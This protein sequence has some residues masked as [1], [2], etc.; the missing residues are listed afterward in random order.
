MKRTAVVGV[1]AVTMALAGMTL[2]AHDEQQGQ[3][4]GQG[5]QAGRAGGG[6]R[7]GRGNNVPP[8]AKGECPQGMTLVRV[9]SCGTPEFPPP[10]IVDYRPRTTLVSTEHLVPK[11]KFPVIDSHNHTTITAANIDQM[12]KEMDENNIRT[13][14]NLSGGA[15]PAGVK[16]KV[17]FIRS[18]GFDEAIN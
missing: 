1:V 12:I 3:A 9:G 11:A 10:S 7:G 5:Q 17:D 14:V 16:T 6:G 13:L 2:A 4:A 18:L 8:D 15:D